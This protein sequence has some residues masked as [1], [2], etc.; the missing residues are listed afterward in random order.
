MSALKGA[1]DNGL[2]DLGFKGEARPFTAHITLARIKGRRRY[3]EIKRE[4]ERLAPS[5]EIDFQV[6]GV[7]L[8]ESVL[9]PSGSEYRIIRDIPLNKE[10]IEDR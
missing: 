7:Q 2:K 1:I 3:K 5:P 6:L 8:I 10:M 9:R 4:L